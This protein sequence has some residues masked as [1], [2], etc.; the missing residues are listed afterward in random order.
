VV[1]NVFGIFLIV[2]TGTLQFSSI[3]DILKEKT[4]L[5]PGIAVI[6]TTVLNGLLTANAKARLV[7]LRWH[8]ALPG[9]RAFSHYA[10]ADPRIDLVALEKM[11]GSAFPVDPLEQNRLWY[12]LYKTVEDRPAVVHVHGEF[13]LLRDYSGLAVLFLVCFG[14]TAIY[15]V[16]SLV[17]VGW[18]VAFLFGQYIVVRQAAATYGIRMVTN[19]LA[20]KSASAAPEEKKAKT[21]PKKSTRRS[22]ENSSG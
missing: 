12:K 16:Q 4:L 6:I 8:N 14:A 17:T 9:H 7:F 18:Y 5:P 20:E 21:T 10:K 11:H 19:V 15:A 1:A 13:L 22:K 2:Q 3:R